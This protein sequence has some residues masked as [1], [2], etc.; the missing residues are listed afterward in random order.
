MGCAMSAEERAAL[1][2]SRQIERNLREDGLQAAKDIKL[3]LLGE[4]TSYSALAATFL[5]QNSPLHRRRWRRGRLVASGVRRT[6][7]LNF[8]FCIFSRLNNIIIFILSYLLVN[9]LNIRN[10]HFSRG[11]MH[12]YYIT[13]TFI[14]L[15]HEHSYLHTG[16]HTHTHTLTIG[17]IVCST[18]GTRARRLDRERLFGKVPTRCTSQWVCVWLFRCSDRNRWVSV[19]V[20]PPSG[21]VSGVMFLNIFLFISGKTCLKVERRC[22]RVSSFKC[23]VVVTSFGRRAE[24]LF[25][26]R[27]YAPESDDDDYARSA[28]ST[29]AHLTPFFRSALFRQ[30]RSDRRTLSSSHEGA[31][32]VCCCVEGGLCRC[33]TGGQYDDEGDEKQTTNNLSF[34]HRESTI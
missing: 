5:S 23:I 17:A 34:S 18:V 1:A 27:R 16:S 8:S 15:S 28:A 12:Y 7:Y 31:G 24:D 26:R 13:M 29:S 30:P 22:V 21:R 14:L 3:L 6:S 4:Q 2:R 25:Y 20:C 10:M 33:W 19:S 9:C 11:R 32:R